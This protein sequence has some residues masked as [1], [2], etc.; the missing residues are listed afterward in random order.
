MSKF[1]VTL[2]G[3]EG[4]FAT[5]NDQDADTLASALHREGFGVRINGRAVSLTY[6]PGYDTLVY[7]ATEEPVLSL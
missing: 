4:Q 3:I 6:G 1:V 2:S 5:D 7:S